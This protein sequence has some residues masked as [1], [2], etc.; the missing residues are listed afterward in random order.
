MSDVAGPERIL[1]IA[2]GFRRARVL[3]SAVEIGV[4]D[5]LSGQP[6]HAAPLA[7]AVGLTAR[8]SLDFLDSLVAMDLLE[9]DAD[10][11]Y[12]NTPEAARHLVSRAPDYIG[13]Q[14]DFVNGGGQYQTWG[15]LTDALRTGTAQGG[16]SGAGGF[17]AFYDD[18]AAFERFMHG[19]SAGIARPARA[20]AAAFPWER[21]A[22]FAD[23][24]TARGCLAA[25]IA[26]RHPHLRGIG[27]DLPRVEPAFMRNIEQR[28]VARAL[29]FQVGDFFA[30][31]LPRADVLVF[32]RVPH[33]WTPA[34]RR[35]LLAKA[36]DAVSPGG[37]VVVVE[38]VIDDARRTELPALIASL[39]MLLHTAGGSEATASD[40]GSW[41]CE[42]GFGEPRVI[43]LANGFSAVVGSKDRD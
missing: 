42:A 30:D 15:K 12:A 13:E 3:L 26:G 16:P 17:D 37:A 14:L 35:T 39:H 41:M 23:I 43:A 10:G 36:F 11:L 34:E 6:L 31:P 27:F 2:F 1:S 20:L 28:G 21:Y 18:P 22:T 8:G 40:Y 32:A 7:R 25:E 24:G 29:R 38:M 5:A 4:F 33:N 9:R 19:M